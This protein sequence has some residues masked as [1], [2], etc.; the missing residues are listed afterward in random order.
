MSIFF[1][2]ALIIFANSGA[3]TAVHEDSP[4]VGSMSALASNAL[5]ETHPECGTPVV[6][7][8]VDDSDGITVI[9]HNPACEYAA[10]FYRAPDTLVWTF[11]VEG[12]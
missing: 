3:P 6:D 4:I 1:A 7:Y 9:A 12:S 5:I 10:S 8:N 11:M 2:L